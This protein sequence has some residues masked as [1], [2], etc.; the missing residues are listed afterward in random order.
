MHVF[1][2]QQLAKLSSDCITQPH[3]DEMKKLM[4]NDQPQ[5]ARPPHQ[6][7]IDHYFTFSDEAGGVNRGP[8]V[9][10]PA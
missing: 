6:L 10:L 2:G 8:A 4:D 3:P 9:R 1:I 7:R 5:Q